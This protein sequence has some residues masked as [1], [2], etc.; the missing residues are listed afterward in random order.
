MQRQ[1]HWC[2]SRVTRVTFRGQR[3]HVKRD[4]ELH[5]AGNKVDRSLDS[6]RGAVS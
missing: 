1:W 2:K 5:L 3:V 4:D 6:L